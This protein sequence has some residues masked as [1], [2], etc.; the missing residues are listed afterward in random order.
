MEKNK[1]KCEHGSLNVSISVTLDYTKNVRRSGQEM[2]L[3]VHKKAKLDFNPLYIAADDSHTGIFE[4]IIDFQRGANKILR[5]VKKLL[6]DG[7]YLKFSIC[8]DSYEDVEE[9]TEYTRFGPFKSRLN[10]LY[11]NEWNYEGDGVE[12]DMGK[13]GGLYLQPNP[14]YTNEKH[15]IWIPWGTDILS[16]LQGAGI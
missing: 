3:D 9:Y 6:S 4:Q 15:D 10:P 2:Q 14:Q 12:M 16:A 8:T 7:Q 1:R 13:D 11:F 5:E